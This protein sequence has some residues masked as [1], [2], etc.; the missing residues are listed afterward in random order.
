[1]PL[2][3]IIAGFFSLLVISRSGTAYFVKHRLK[4][5]LLPLIIFLPLVLTAFLTT[6]GWAV[7]NVANPSTV[8]SSIK[9]TINTPDAPQPPFTTSHLWFLYYLIQFCLIFALGYRFLGNKLANVAARINIHTLVW[10]FPLLMVP[11]LYSQAAPH[12]APDKILPQLWSYGFY[13]VSFILGLILYKKPVLIKQ[14]KPYVLPLTLLSLIIFYFVYMAISITPMTYPPKQPE[15]LT[16]FAV[17]IAEAYLA[18]WLSF[19]CIFVAKHIFNQQNRMM[20]FVSRSSYWVYIVH[21]PLLFLIQFYLLDVNLHWLI[22]FLIATFSTIIIGFLSYFIFVKYTP[23][24]WLLN[25]REKS[26]V[27]G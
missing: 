18:V 7:E 26:K 13:G 23:I 16:H 3:F 14:F 2:F 24:G 27:N 9:L 20:V 15:G 4:R 6:I 1:M 10:L 8:L 19:V 17:A 12:L 25:G 5:L 21:L 11:A 22:K